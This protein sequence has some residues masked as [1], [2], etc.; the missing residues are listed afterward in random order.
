MPSYDSVS[1]TN[2]VPLVV[3]IVDSGSPMPEEEPQ[4]AQGSDTQL[5]TPSL[6]AEESLYPFST[7][8]KVYRY[9]VF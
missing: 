4:K 3:H 6:A 9:T 2:G 1:K 7:V 5:A 8:D